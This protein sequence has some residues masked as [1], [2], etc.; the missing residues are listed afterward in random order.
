MKQPKSTEVSS[1]KTP[2]RHT[3]VSGLARIGDIA[4]EHFTANPSAF[5]TSFP[6]LA[7]AIELHLQSSS[8]RYERVPVFEGYMTERE[9]VFKMRSLTEIMDHYNNRQTLPQEEGRRSVELAAA[10][11]E[12]ADEHKETLYKIIEHVLGL[13]LNSTKTEKI[14]VQKG[15]SV[16]HTYN[17]DSFVTRH[18]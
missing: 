16:H 9:R 1:L 18:V 13:P 11:R 3:R 2:K 7:N 14:T 12:H 17:I 4:I 15:K 10:L 8:R 6:E 5:W